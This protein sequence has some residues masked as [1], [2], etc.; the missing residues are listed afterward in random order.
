[1][2]GSIN[3]TVAVI[4]GG[5]SCEHDISVITGCLAKG[6]FGTDI[7]SIYIDKD[8]RFYLVGNDWTPRAHL[9]RKGKPLIFLTGESSVA[10]VRRRKLE[11]IP[12]YA[13]VNCCHGLNGEDGCIAALC[14][15][16]EIPLV[17]SDL[18]AGAVAMDKDLCK[19]VLSSYDFP[20]VEGVT[21][22]S[23]QPAFEFA[24]THYPVIVKP[25]LLGSSIG[26]SVARDDAQLAAAVDNALHYCPRVLVERF[27]DCVE[28]NCAVMHVGGEVVTSRVEMPVTA[29]EL[30]TFTDKYIEGDAP[31]KEVPKDIA[32]TVQ[33][34]T[35]DI[36]E[37]MNFKGVVRVDFLYDKNSGRLYVNEINTT[38]GSLAF[39]LWQGEYSRTR[40]GEA[41]VD[42]AV[43]DYR[44]M[45]SFTYVFPSS[46]LDGG[47]GNK[48]GTK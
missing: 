39:G 1:M 30:L 8:N 21:V 33:A 5:K 4:Y 43:S 34:M 6:Y 15:L 31:S 2:S 13:A 45:Q 17:G 44:Q 10:V 14:R 38:P 11:K 35:A 28:Y 24:R 26:V 20:T 9:E 47:T 41:L 23:V 3:R 42:Q 32:K 29:H 22:T 7:V 36:Y 18:A 19:R 25:T 37:T 16:A 12:I 27:V 40:F 46:V 48:R